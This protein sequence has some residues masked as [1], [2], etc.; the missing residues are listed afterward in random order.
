MLLHVDIIV[1][2]RT[3][4]YQYTKFFPGVVEDG[5]AVPCHHILVIF[6]LFNHS[7]VT[8]YPIV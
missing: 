4:N 7:V 2:T 3:F 6:D 8:M 1:E 5:L